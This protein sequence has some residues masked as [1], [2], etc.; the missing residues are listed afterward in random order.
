VAD[1]TPKA[2]MIGDE[3]VQL[4]SFSAY[5]MIEATEVLARILKAVPDL[6]D[7]VADFR[8]NYAERHAATLDR[9]TV[10]FQYPAKAAGVSDAAWEAVGQK[11]TMPGDASMPEQI[12]GVFPQILEAAKR[13]LFDLLAVVMTPS[14]AFETG[15]AAG[16]TT[17]QITA[18]NRRKIMHKATVRQL[19]Q[20]ILAA[21]DHLQGE[22]DGAASKEDLGK[23]LGLF[24]LQMTEEGQAESQQQSDAP[25][26]SRAS[27]TRSPAGRAKKSSTASRGASSSRSAKG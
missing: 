10:E 3:P 6:T 22:I 5:K 16:E 7:Q 20:L 25:A 26:S 23:L 11:L 8:K 9:A 24:G 17:A 14:S 4:T 1:A 2:L 18:E 21:A 15:D 19:V 27:R 13:E 12:M